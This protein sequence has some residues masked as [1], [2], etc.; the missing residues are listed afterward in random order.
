MHRLDEQE[1]CSKQGDNNAQDRRS[2]AAEPRSENHG[3]KQ[4][5]ERN[6]IAHKRAQRPSDKQRNQN[7]C[8]RCGVTR[9]T[10]IEDSGEQRVT[11]GAQIVPP[12]PEGKRGLC[13]VNRL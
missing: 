3:G 12:F 9:W 5:D 7:R 10:V 11:G 1:P 8:E 6:V 13:G 2:D 4:R